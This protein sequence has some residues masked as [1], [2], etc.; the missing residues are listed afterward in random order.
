MSSNPKTMVF[1]ST[2]GNEK[3]VMRIY[4]LNIIKKEFKFGIGNFNIS[5]SYSN[6]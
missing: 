4:Y 5:S 6:C 1:F 3:L 2:S